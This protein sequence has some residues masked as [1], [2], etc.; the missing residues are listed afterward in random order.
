MLLNKFKKREAMKL[1]QVHQKSTK[2]T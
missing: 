2:L 1:T